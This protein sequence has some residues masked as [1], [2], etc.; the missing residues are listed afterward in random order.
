MPLGIALIALLFFFIYKKRATFIL[1]LWIVSIRRLK[2][3]RS[4][5]HR[6]ET[7][8]KTYYFKSFAHLQYIYR[9]FYKTSCR[10]T[11]AI[12]EKTHE[13]WKTSE[14]LLLMSKKHE[15][16]EEKR[17]TLQSEVWTHMTE[18]VFILKGTTRLLKSF[19]NLFKFNIIET[20]PRLSS[21]QIK[22]HQVWHQWRLI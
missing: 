2:W 5:F 11:C 20:N 6:G 7:L 14:Q 13:V 4:A 8:W 10:R 21:S 16:R 15:M 19:N 3:T 1:L 12:R 22:Q 18:F 17:F 9:T